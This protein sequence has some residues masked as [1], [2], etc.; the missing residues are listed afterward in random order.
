MRDEEE[1][2]DKLITPPQH[3]HTHIIIVFFMKHPVNWNR[4]LCELIFI[5][6]IKSVWLVFNQKQIPEKSLSILFFQYYHG[7]KSLLLLFTLH[8]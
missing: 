5:F 8:Y 3:R 2:E 4:Y 6:G 1:Y 7:L